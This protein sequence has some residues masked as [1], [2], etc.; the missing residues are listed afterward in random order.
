MK[1]VAVFMAV[2]G[3][4]IGWGA[5]QQFGYYGPESSPFWV[6]VVATPA[7]LLFVIAAVMLWLRGHLV[8]QLVLTAA[9]VMTIVTIF[10]TVFD[11]MGP[12]ATVVGLAGAFVAAGWVWRSRA[13]A[14]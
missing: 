2:V 14:V 4:M 9:M 10:G 11:V 13:V 8:R 3:L 5:A 6:G 12:P 1:A 7:G